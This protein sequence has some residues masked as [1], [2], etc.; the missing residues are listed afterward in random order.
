MNEKREDSMRWFRKFGIVL[1][2]VLAVLLRQSWSEDNRRD[3]TVQTD[4]SCGRVD[5]KVITHCTYKEG[6]LPCLS[7][8]QYVVIGNKKI[9]S[10]STLLKLDHTI[11][12]IAC[13]K[14]KN[15]EW[16]IELYYANLGNCSVCEYYELYDING[17]LIATDR[18]KF[19]IIHNHGSVKII[20]S[21]NFNKFFK[22]YGDIFNKLKFK[23]VNFK[24]INL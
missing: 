15:N 16:F 7:D 21:K 24:D 5:V 17:N 14:S 10:S 18:E 1:I 23:K 3:Y 2:S 13:Y 22:K 12:E 8:S 9:V 19:K 20:E 6:S 4:F 11:S